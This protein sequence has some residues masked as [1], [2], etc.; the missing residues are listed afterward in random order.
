MASGR[1]CPALEERLGLIGWFEIIKEQ[2]IDYGELNL[3]KSLISLSEVI[4]VT[5]EIYLGQEFLIGRDTNRWY[6]HCCA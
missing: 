4:L 3:H 1:G 5:Y 2:E 6:Y